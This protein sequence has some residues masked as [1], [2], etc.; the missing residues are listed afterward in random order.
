MQCAAN[1]DFQ[2][3]LQMVYRKKHPLKHLYPFGCL[4]YVKLHKDIVQDWKFDSRAQPCIYLGS[5][6]VAGHK[7]AMGYTIDFNNT[8]HI[9]RHVH[10][11]QFWVDQ[12][13]FPFGK[14]GEERVTTL[15]FGK[16]LSGKEE[17]EQEI[18][19]PPVYHSV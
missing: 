19:T 13:F 2:S 3:P 5:G 10:S 6:E 16:H 1:P 17:F 8:G 4:L 15:S 7:S 18:P 9:G 12:T 11:T 14:S